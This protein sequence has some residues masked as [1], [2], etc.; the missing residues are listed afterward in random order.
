MPYHG[1]EEFL[2]W[3][4]LGCC[5]VCGE[6][7]NHLW[8]SYQLRITETARIYEYD[9]FAFYCCVDDLPPVFS[10]KEIKEAIDG[11]VEGMYTMRYIRVFQEPKPDEE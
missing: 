6:P 1:P 9:T 3:P 2:T 10:A 5:Q 7:E 11:N 8:V 4:K